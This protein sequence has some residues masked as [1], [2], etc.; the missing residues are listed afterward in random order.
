M[1]KIKIEKNIL[2]E[3]DQLALKIRDKFDKAGVFAINIMAAP[4]AGKTTTIIETIKALKDQFRIAVIEGDVVDID[5]D[6]V[7]NLKVSSILANTG[8]ACHLDATMVQKAL[9]KIDLSKLDLIIVENVGNL[10][11]P[12]GFKIGTHLNVV[13]ASVPE[14]DD[15]PYKYPGMFKGA[16]VL[17]LNKSDY[18]AL[19]DFDLKYF[20]KGVQLLNKDVTFFTISAKK[21]IGVGDWTKW[22][23]SHISEQL[24]K[25]S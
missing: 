25:R 13:I 17:L 23:A 16:D 21:G 12:M 5:V 20:Q 1:K 15:K 8:G 22:L 19:E 3:N 14:G 11:C 24:S 4:G 10:I 7:S 2:N 6:R 9:D 18:L